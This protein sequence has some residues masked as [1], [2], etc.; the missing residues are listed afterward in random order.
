MKTLSNLTF[1]LENLSKTEYVK[2]EE[3]KPNL[4]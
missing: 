1:F 3:W 2:K 4:T